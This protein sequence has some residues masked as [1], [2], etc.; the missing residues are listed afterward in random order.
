MKVIFADRLMSLTRHLGHFHPIDVHSMV[1]LPHFYG[2]GL[3]LHWAQ[4]RIQAL[5]CHLGSS[6]TGHFPAVLRHDDQCSPLNSPNGAWRDLPLTEVLPTQ[7][8]DSSDSDETPLP[9]QAQATSSLGDRFDGQDEAPSCQG[10]LG[11][12]LRSVLDR[13]LDDSR[14]RR[15]P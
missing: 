9:L 10:A 6:H 15:L 13:V 2:Q 5:I 4:Y 3:E 7:T 1:E 14:A 12:V 8:E 11:Q